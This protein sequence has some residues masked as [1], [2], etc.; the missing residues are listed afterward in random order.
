MFQK[1]E[2]AHVTAGVLGMEGRTGW[3]FSPR[4]L[5]PTETELAGMEC[6]P[7]VTVACWED[8]WVWANLSSFSGENSCTPM[9]RAAVWSVMTAEVKKAKYTEDRASQDCGSWVS[10]EWICARGGLC[11]TMCKTASTVHVSAGPKFWG[12]IQD[13]G[14]AAAVVNKLHL[15]KHW[16]SLLAHTCLLTEISAVC[17]RL[18]LG[19]VPVQTQQSLRWQVVKEEL[20]DPEQRRIWGL[21][22]C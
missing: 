21:A 11:Q 8:R 7:L 1:A 22:E 16:T 3:T 6:H 17:L 15:N 14:W 4:L 18:L 12:L 9:L 5:P 13:A 20:L 2:L 10:W 19:S